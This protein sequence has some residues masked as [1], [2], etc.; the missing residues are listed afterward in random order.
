MKLSDDFSIT[1]AGNVYSVLSRENAQPAIG[2][3]FTKLLC[4]WEVPLHSFRGWQLEVAPTIEPRSKL[5]GPVG[6]LRGRAMTRRE[7]TNI[8]L[9]LEILRQAMVRSARERVDTIE[10]RLALRCLLPHV[11]ER[12]P[13]EAFWAGASGE[14]DLGRGQSCTAAL[15]GIARQLRIAGRFPE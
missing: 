15:N 2:H 4:G 3:Y 12:W 11:A 7:R 9:A 14:Q 1:I 10:V 13:L 5:A 8:T 6:K